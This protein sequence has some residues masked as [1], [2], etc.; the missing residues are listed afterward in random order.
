MIGREI[1]NPCLQRICRNEKPPFPSTSFLLTLRCMFRDS[2]LGR[3]QALWYAE[4]GKIEL[5]SETLP[6]LRAGDALVRTDV[7]AI[8]RGTERLVLEGK[9]PISE[10][11]RM[12]G[13]NMDGDFPHPVKYGYCA[14]G[15]VEEGPATVMG[16]R[17]FALHP[18]QEAFVVPAASLTVLPDALPSARATLSANMETALN[19]LWD[20]GAGPGDRIAVIGG[21][22]VGCLIASL[23]AALPGADV[24]LVDTVRSRKAIAESFGCAFALPGSA[25]EDCDVVFH[26]SASAAGLAT[27]LDCAGFE[28]VVVEASWF[29]ATPVPVL[30]GQS[31]HSG[32]LKFVSTQ[33]GQVSTSRRARWSHA[34]R[35]D[36]AMS[37]LTD[38]RYDALLGE[39][40]AFSLAPERLP[41]LIRSTDGFAPLLRY[42]KA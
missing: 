12:R 20:S 5:R 17:V 30:L 4:P 24:T 27:A 39:E 41:D 3:A 10:H 6:I 38:K 7:S 33:V 28:G 13:P 2:L 1:H 15:V 25:P 34:R 40:L 23:A 21:G 31:F 32:R 42:K 29:G 11:E 9:V 14:V 26:A 22:V 16:K 19:A 8:S 37:L 36:K 18:H 35:M